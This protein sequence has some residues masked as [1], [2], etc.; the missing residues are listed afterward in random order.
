LKISISFA[1]IRTG[2]LENT[3]RCLGRQTLPKDEWELIMIDDIP[4]DRSEYVM[5]LAR[6]EDINVKWMRSKP[7][8]WKSNRLLGNA[9]NTGFIHSDGELVVFLDDYTW[10]PETFL[11]EHWKI[12]KETNMAVI[13]RVKAIK[14]QDKIESGGDITVIGDD[15]RY[16]LFFSQG[17]GKRG[18]AGYAWFYTFNTSAPLKKIISIN[19]YDEEF[20]CTGEEDIDLG[21]RLS[22]LGM[23]FTFKT[24]PEI[25]VFHM[26]HGGQNARIKCTNCGEDL[27]TYESCWNSVVTCPNCKKDLNISLMMREINVHRR[28]EDTE[29]HKVVKGMYSTEHDG[30][31]GLLEKN[32]RKHPQLVNQGNFDLCMA[33]KNR[34]LYPYKRN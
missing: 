28:Y 25:T 3:F 31:W 27:S 26:Q 16:K 18:N 2:W 1:T 8:H 22:R 20:D 15:Q 13:G 32:R 14:Y 30:S 24:H 6:K 23:Q 10:V 19:G 12:Y 11:E 33:R 29:V 17:T 9:R 5:E 34:L 21:E 7:N 4:E